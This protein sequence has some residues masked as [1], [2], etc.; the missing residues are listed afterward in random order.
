MCDNMPRARPGPLGHI[1]RKFTK[2]IRYGKFYIH[3]AAGKSPKDN[4]SRLGERRA[5]ANG[6]A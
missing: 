5:Y 1:A 4:D 2:G 3:F 6:Q